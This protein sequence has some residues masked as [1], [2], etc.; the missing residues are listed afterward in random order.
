MSEFISDML[1]IIIQKPRYFFSVSPCRMLPFQ[2]LYVLLLDHSDAVVI[3]RS[4][5]GMFC[6]LSPSFRS[7]ISGVSLPSILGAVLCSARQP[8]AGVLSAAP[9]P[10]RCGRL[11]ALL[12]ALD[13]AATAGLE[14]VCAASIY[15]YH[16]ISAF[17]P[18][19]LKL[20][21]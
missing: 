6:S 4:V 11:L 17:P 14:Q 18:P 15:I 7:G 13:C 10:A 1:Y 19:C 21:T 5:K 12:T 9:G 2:N 16:M 3:K 20:K 8:T